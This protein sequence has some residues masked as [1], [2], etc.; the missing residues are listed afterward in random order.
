[1][2]NT[3]NGLFQPGPRWWRRIVNVLAWFLLFV[4]VVVYVNHQRRED[5]RRWC[6][7]FGALTTPATT[8]RGQEIARIMEDMEADLGCDQGA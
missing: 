4:L 1:M 2:T 6:R 5:D 7:L 8:E 3:T